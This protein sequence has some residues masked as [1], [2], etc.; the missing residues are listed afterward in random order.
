MLV[1]LFLSCYNYKFEA[2]RF[3]F[4]MCECSV[5]ERHIHCAFTFTKELYGIS[6]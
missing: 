1:E 3:D 2:V 6:G 4:V 5:Y